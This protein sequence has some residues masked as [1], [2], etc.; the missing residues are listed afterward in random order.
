MVLNLKLKNY[1]F[2][3]KF[4]K[5]NDIKPYDYCNQCSIFSKIL[6][7]KNKIKEIDNM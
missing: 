2:L 3:P 6:Q 1:K 7:V 4:K 5:F